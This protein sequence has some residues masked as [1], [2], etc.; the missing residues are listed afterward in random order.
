MGGGV[1][2]RQPPDGGLIVE[3][4]VPHAVGAAQPPEWVLT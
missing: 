2:L 1:R 3:V 4:R